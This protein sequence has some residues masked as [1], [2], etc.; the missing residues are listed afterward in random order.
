M[1]Q[2]LKNKEKGF[3]CSA[4]AIVLLAI[5]LVFYRMLTAVSFETTERPVLVILTAFGAI[6]FSLIASYK[7]F[8][9]VPSILAYAAT[10]LAFFLL[11]EGRASYL[12]FYFSGDVMDTGLSPYMVG[13]FVCFLLAM[14]AALFAVIFEEDKGGRP[15]LT[16]ADW[17]VLLPM[18][19][20]VGVLCL[21]VALNTNS[22]S[23][24]S[25]VTAVQTTQNESTAANADG[26]QAEAASEANYKKPRTSEDVWQEYS[27]KEFA[28]EDVTGKPIAYQLIG[29]GEVDAGGP[30]AFDALL[31]LYEN[32]EVMIDVYGMGNG[33]RYYGYWTNEGDEN[34]WFCVMYYTVLGNGQFCTIDY[35][36]DLT[37][38]FNEVT[39]NIALGLADGGQFVRSIPASGDGSV[40]FAS[41]EDWYA[42]F[43]YT[44]PEILYRESNAQ[45]AAEVNENLLFSFLSDSEN[46]LLDINNDGTYTFTFVS[47][48]L[49]ET[50]SWEWKDWTFTLTDAKDRVTTVT[51]DTET[52]AL[53]F[54]FVAVVD[55]RV[56]RDFSAEAE[57]WGAAFNGEGNY[58]PTAA[59]AAEAPAVLFPFVADAESFQLDLLSDGTYEFRFTTMNVSETGTWTWENWTLTLT[60][61]QGRTAVAAIDNETH[62]LNITFIPDASEQLVRDYTAEATVWGAAFNGEGNYTPNDAPTAGAA[63]QYVFTGSVGA[64]L[65]TTITLNADG[66]ATMVCEQAM[67]DRTGTWTAN[68]DGQLTVTFAEETIEIPDPSQPF[69]VAV[70]AG[71]Y[72]VDIEMTQE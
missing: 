2:F 53:N 20:V 71:G 21:V 63:L 12:A 68:G 66:S 67:M 41:V 56:N 50:G 6:L 64:F 44:I 10:T 23:A 40:Q 70:S 15:A 62:A 9:K 33:Y 72:V 5:G 32:G 48:G 14:V 51:P 59:P 45:A 54:N 19:A 28:D 69:T 47:A 7:D 57:V 17:K 34:L 3:Y 30:Q 65:A 58:T 38:H 42:Q 25:A 36:Y 31:N 16:A 11:L 49:V 52:H 43:D 55:D 18:A 1:K 39:I 26:P 35:G 60:T 8:G 27:A 24:A 13:S 61:P 29:Y 46:F 22:G 4:A 37:G